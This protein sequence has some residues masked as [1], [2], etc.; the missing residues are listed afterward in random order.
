[1]KYHYGVVGLDYP[2]PKPKEKV[3][4][5]NIGFDDTELGFLRLK[6]KEK[7]IESKTFEP[8]IIVARKNFYGTEEN[9]NT[10]EK[11]M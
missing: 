1:M 5:E 9:K 6:S 3:K 7:K 10:Y 8:E 4:K 2:I 11:A